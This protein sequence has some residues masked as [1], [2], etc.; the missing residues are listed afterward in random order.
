MA[1]NALSMSAEHPGRTR[2]CRSVS[3][4]KFIPQAAGLTVEMPQAEALAQPPVSCG[5]R[6]ALS[7]DCTRV[8]LLSA[9]GLAPFDGGSGWGGAI[10]DLLKIRFADVMT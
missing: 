10:A 6:S 5:G 3:R 1:A 2:N 7:P 8:E 9:F 4:D